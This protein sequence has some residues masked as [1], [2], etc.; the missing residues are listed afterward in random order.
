LVLEV[1]RVLEGGLVEYEEVGGAGEEI[2][3]KDTEEP[4]ILSVGAIEASRRLFYHVMRYNDTAWRR[5]S[6][7]AQALMYAYLEGSTEK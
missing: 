3:D 5:Q 6:S 2:V 1:S 4:A 7:R